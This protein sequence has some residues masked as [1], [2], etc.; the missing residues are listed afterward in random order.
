MDDI[1][2]MRN[3]SRNPNEVSKWSDHLTGDAI[4]IP[5]N[6][7]GNSNSSSVQLYNYLKTDE[8]LEWLEQNNMYVL[9]H[10]NANS[11]GYHF[12]IGYADQNFTGQRFTDKLNK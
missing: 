9:I 7:N 12:H 11:D 4:D 6:P 2:E 3:E 5:F 10:K 1:T 8:G